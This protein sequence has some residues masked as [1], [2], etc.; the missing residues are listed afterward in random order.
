M[1]LNGANHSKPLPPDANGCND[2][3]MK[4]IGTNHSETFALALSNANGHDCPPQLVAVPGEA[5]NGGGSQGAATPPVC[6]EPREATLGPQL[7]TQMSLL[8]PLT[9]ALAPCRTALSWANHVVTLLLLVCLV[10]PSLQLRRLS[11]S[12]WPIAAPAIRR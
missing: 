4:L 11:I 5:T 7:P 1:K 3:P 9:A 10:K 2:P 6:A 12:C 8:R